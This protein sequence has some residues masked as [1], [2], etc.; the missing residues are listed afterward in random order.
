MDKFLDTHDHPKLNKEDINHP[1]RPITHK[2]I[3]A[4]IKSLP[5]KKSPGPDSFTAEFCLKNLTPLLLKLIHKI[6]W[7]ENTAVSSMKPVLY[8]FLN[9]TRT[10]QK[11][12]S[13]SQSL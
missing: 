1:N 7:K 8:S 2:E 12:R 6:Q 13:T 10:Q 11:E 4:A 9:Q 3:E 5:K